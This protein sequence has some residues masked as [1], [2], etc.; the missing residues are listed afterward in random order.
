METVVNNCNMKI[1]HIY[2]INPIIIY[3]FIVRNKISDNILKY[4]I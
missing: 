4:M 3:Y 2:M 1:I